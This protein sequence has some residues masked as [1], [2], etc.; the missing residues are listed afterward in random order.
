MALLHLLSERANRLGYRLRVAHFDHG[1]RPDSD[2]DRRLVESFAQVYGH[3]FHCERASLAGLGEAQARE[4]RYGFLGRLA[5]EVGADGIVTAHHQDDRSETVVM[6]ALRGA[7]RTGSTALKSV[8]GLYRPLLSVRKD[9]LIDYAKRH[10][11]PWREDSTNADIRYRRNAVRHELLP[12]AREVRPDF[13]AELEAVVAELDRLNERIDRKFEQLFARYGRQTASSL[14]MQRQPLMDLSQH[15]LEEFLIWLVRRVQP[16]AELATRPVQQLAAWVRTG[17]SGNERPAG[18]GL[19]FHLT[20]DAVV[21][22]RGDRS[23]QQLVAQELLPGTTVRF[24]RHALG[25]GGLVAPGAVSILVPELSLKVRK[26]MDGDR[27]APVGMKGRKKLQDIFVDAKIERE[28]RISWPVVVDLVRDEV[29]WVP[30][31]ALSRY[32]AAGLEDAPT[33]RLTHEVL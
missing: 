28:E 27:I 17:L 24:G 25:Y 3:P 31:L 11:L 30:R 10:E 12:A 33:Y 13:D 9:E 20:Y 5:E 2:A 7:G 32:Y 18:A 8:D 14:R 21:L 15:T 16:G 29:V 19:K 4:A 23:L 6:N 22:D 1:M 26:W